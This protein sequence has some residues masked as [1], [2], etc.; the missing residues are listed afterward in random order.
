[1]TPLNDSKEGHD[2]NAVMPQP[3]PQPTSTS[4]EQQQLQQRYTNP[5]LHT[6]KGNALRAEA[7]IRTF[8]NAVDVLKNLLDEYETHTEQHVNF[9][10]NIYSLRPD[11]SFCRRHF[12]KGGI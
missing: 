3:Q 10:K 7:A 5:S 4:T 8:A 6:D 9:V 2:D 12:N 11:C 1:M